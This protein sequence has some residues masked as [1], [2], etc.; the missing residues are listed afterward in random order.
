MTE[1]YIGKFGYSCVQAKAIFWTKLALENETNDANTDLKLIYRDYEVKIMI[2]TKG[3]YDD[4][5]QKAGNQFALTVDFE[6]FEAAADTGALSGVA[7]ALPTLVAA[8][9]ATAF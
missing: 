9:V 1:W 5:S 8:I 4:S 3:D 6:D 2:G 7:L